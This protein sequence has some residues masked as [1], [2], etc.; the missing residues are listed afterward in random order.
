MIKQFLTKE[1]ILAVMRHVLTT[2]GG[3]LVAKGIASNSDIKTIGEFITDPKT[4]GTAMIIIGVVKS[5]IQK[6]EQPKVVN[7]AEQ[8]TEITTLKKVVV[9]ATLLFICN[10]S[11]A[12]SN[13]LPTLNV[14][15]NIPLSTNLQAVA[16]DTLGF[17][18]PLIPY[19]TNR[20]Y[21]LSLD[22]LF[23]SEKKFGGLGDFQVGIN[24]N[25]SAGVGVSYID[26]RW[27]V[28]AGSIKLGMT[29]NILGHAFQLSA[30]TGSAI[31]L[32]HA[33]LENQSMAIAYTKWDLG[34]GWD[35]AVDGGVGKETSVKGELFMFGGFLHYH[36]KNW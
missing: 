16:I 15:T 5:I 22:G 13:E 28:E 36:P 27:F 26:N 17:L 4:I 7:T 2:G 18:E 20:D 10:C 31:P 12:Q 8:T 29:Q 24:Q 9:A 3:I 34:K 14:S 23:T 35:L 6:F 21:T 11:Y 25:L 33:T 19:L 1:V 30:E 32:A